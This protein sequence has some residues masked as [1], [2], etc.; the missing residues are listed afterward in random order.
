MAL[1]AVLSRYLEA[2]DATTLGMSGFFAETWLCAIRI[3]L[4]V[5]R[6]VFGLRMW[7]LGRTLERARRRLGLSRLVLVYRWLGWKKIVAGTVIGGLMGVVAFGPQHVRLSPI[8]LP[9]HLKTAGH[10]PEVFRNEVLERIRDIERGVEAVPPS[11]FVPEN[12]D[13]DIPVSGLDFRNW[14][15]PIRWLLRKEVLDIEAQVTLESDDFKQP[16]DLSRYRIVVR[17]ERGD[18]RWSS[19]P[20]LVTAANDRELTLH[21]SKLILQQVHP[22]LLAYYMESVERNV[23]G[24]QRILDEAIASGF[25]VARAHW[26]KAIFFEREGRYSEGLEAL[27]KARTAGADFDGME[28][29]EFKLLVGLPDFERAQAL[30]QRM[31]E[32][33]PDDSDVLTSYGIWYERQNRFKEALSQ[34]RKA[35]AMAPDDIFVELNIATALSNLRQ[36]EEAEPYAARAVEKNPKDGEARAVLAQIQM[37]RGRPNEAA[38][39]FRAALALSPRSA[40]VHRLF[41]VYLEA[42]NDRAATREYQTAVV[43]DPTDGYAHYL[44]GKGLLDEGQVD[45]AI[46]ALDAAIKLLPSLADPYYAKALALLNLRRR[47]EAEQV[48]TQAR[49]L[50]AEDPFWFSHWGAELA[51]QGHTDDAI[52]YMQR[53]VELAPDMTYAQVNLMQALAVARRYE[54]ALSEVRK[55]QVAE[56]EDVSHRL[57]EARML[58]QLTRHA[59]VVAAYENVPARELTPVD[60][61]NRAIAL[62]NLGRLEDSYAAYQRVIELTPNN[63]DPYYQQGNIRGVQGRPADAIPRFIEAL[64]RNENAGDIYVGLATANAQLN[65]FSASDM[66]FQNAARLLPQDRTFYSDWA[67][68]QF[69]WGGSLYVSGRTEAIQASLPHYRRAAA[70]APAVARYRLA[71][72]RALMQLNQSGEAQTELQAAVRLDPKNF[73]PSFFLSGVFY[74]RGDYENSLT[75]VQRAIALEPNEGNLYRVLADNLSQLGRGAEAQRAIERADELDKKRSNK[76]QAQ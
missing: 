11:G 26:M 59:E 25:E 61:R 29:T 46:A 16:L 42:Q 21:V 76:L 68:L 47:A 14:I 63:W 28:Q 69:N 27:V 5:E 56:P 51:T 20:A 74:D 52:P 58:V 18:D 35:L 67:M 38:E 24:A 45:T 66:A 2:D 30:L 31:L 53:A 44:L 37:D 12:F 23:R 34:F 55:V 43:L 65:E 6:R 39:T 54:D 9:Q 3:R 73:L 41:G 8:E 7:I 71:L 13:F 33:N 36:F 57:F 60:H 64:Y 32:E 22:V 72:G 75:W 48:F 19:G 70:L 50:K 1:F 40:L 62:R 49:R 4:R 10:V 15:Q 17:V